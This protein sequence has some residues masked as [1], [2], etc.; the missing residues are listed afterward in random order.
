MEVLEEG[1]VKEGW[2]SSE[3]PIASNNKAVAGADCLL[4]QPL[5]SGGGGDVILPEAMRAGVIQLLE[6]CHKDNVLSQG[7]VISTA[8]IIRIIE[9]L[10]ACFYASFLSISL[11]EMLQRKLGVPQLDLESIEVCTC[12]WSLSSG[13]VPIYH[14]ISRDFDMAAAHELTEIARKV[15]EEEATPKEGLALIHAFEMSPNFGKFE[16][17]YRA[18]PG[19]ILV[20]PLLATCSS[21]A[22]FKGAWIDIGFAGLTALAARA[23]HYSAVAGNQLVGKT[24][25]MLISIVTALIATIG[26]T[27]VPNGACFTA[28]AL[29]ALFWLLHGTAFMM[30]LTEMHSGELICGVTRL[31]LAVI[32]TFGL[33]FGASVGLWMA[34]YGVRNDSI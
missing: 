12:Q 13:L 3:P 8:F 20:M 27:V 1:L 15:L 21:F 7:D 25:D 17:F 23:I 18:M 19:R 30:S 16:N 2:S 28:E 24:Q 6:Q 4:E 10:R 32:N 34:A 11:A 31:A 33:A 22:F 29:G 14:R 26:M 9:A 5:A